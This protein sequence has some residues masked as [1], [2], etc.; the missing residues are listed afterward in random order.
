MEV[1]RRVLAGVHFS[2]EIEIFYRMYL[3]PEGMHLNMAE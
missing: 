2:A 1:Y 3:V